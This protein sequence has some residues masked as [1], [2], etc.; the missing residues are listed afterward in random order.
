MRE[1][2]QD[3]E[4]KNIKSVDI[5]SLASNSDPG[6]QIGSVMSVLQEQINE[7]RNLEKQAQKRVRNNHNTAST[8]HSIVGAQAYLNKHSHSNIVSSEYF[9]DNP[10]LNRLN[11]QE[12]FAILN[13]C[14][15][16][17]NAIKHLKSKLDE[18]RE[19]NLRLN[20]S[21]ANLNDNINRTNNEI[22]IK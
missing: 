18:S 1:P 15:I 10:K 2:A 5:S 6:G 11:M 4:S 22:K 20:K 19:L 14:M 21:F 8:T 16:K 13:D 17:F 7:I 9:N 3:T 12:Y